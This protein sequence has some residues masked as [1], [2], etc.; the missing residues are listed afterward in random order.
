MI[1][2]APLKK[3]P[4][5]KCSRW[6]V[7]VYN[8]ETKKYDWHTVRGTRDDA[9][10]FERKF[11]SAKLNGDYTGPLERKSFEEVANLFLDD[12]R[13]DNRRFSTLEEY[14]TEL[15]LRLLPPADEKLPPLGPGNIRN[16]KRADLKAHF[17]ALRKKGCTVSQVN[18][19]IKAAKAV[20][21]YAFDS[22]YVTS[23]VMQR[24]PKLQRVEG[25]RRANRGIFSEV[26]LKAIFESATPFEL[27]LTGTLSI[28]GPRPGEIY[29]LDWSAVFLEVEKPYF[30][31]ERTWCSKSFR[32]YPP[33]TT[34][35]RR[36]VPISA[37]LAE[38]LREHRART[39]GMGLVFPSDVG[40]PLNK[41]NV[42]KRVWIPLL[43][44]AKV[45]YRDLYSLRWTFVS[46]ARASGEVPF[47]VSRVIGHARS[48]IV[49]T[50][51]AHT[52]DSG[53]A[54]VSDSVAQ[55]AGLTVGPTAEPPKPTAPSGRPTLRVID[56][57][58]RA[59]RSENQR[60]I[61]KTIENVPDGASR[62]GTSD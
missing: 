23:N 60:D 17:N 46:L 1:K 44:R 62:E 11:E 24:Y 16:I 25:E 38:V 14:Q 54:G 43:L 13:A 31:I 33:K 28:S 49:D 26:E 41:A 15:K 48:T 27:A 50:I 7:I 58:R 56:G 35:G 8:K 57:G 19:S 4:P 42:R 36:T 10:A 12:R 9:K 40:T 55:R 53:V 32:F 2:R 20:F 6:H 59:A 51:Y 29:A 5:G 47:N 3:D 34:A 18:K 61:R 22:E 45:P 37:W 30:R 21:T 52:V 39:G